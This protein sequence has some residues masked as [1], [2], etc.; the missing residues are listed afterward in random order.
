[1]IPDEAKLMITVRS[2]SDATRQHLLDGIARIAKGEAI[3]AGLSDDRLPVVTVEQ[4]YTP[5][6]FNT[7]DFTEEMGALFTAHF[8]PSRVE[9][10]PASMG[11]EDFGRYVRADK[12][13]RSMIFWVG[14]VPA[15]KMAAA[16]AGKAT[17]PSLHSA[18]WA[19]D[20]EAVIGTGA[21][22]LTGAALDILK[23]G[24]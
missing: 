24:R 9:K 8:G 17:L 7:P 6:T 2:Y 21:R 10:T 5:A 3:A 4:R 14:G 20:A 23:K 1:V 13:I 18:Y 11:G 16:K 19:P 12:S 22:A 15:D